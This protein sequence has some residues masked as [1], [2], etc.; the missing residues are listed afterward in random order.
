MSLYDLTIRKE[1][2]YKGTKQEW[3]A[4]LKQGEQRFPDRISVAKIWYR[5]HILPFLKFQPE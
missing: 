2:I 5:E 1:I 4:L 3:E